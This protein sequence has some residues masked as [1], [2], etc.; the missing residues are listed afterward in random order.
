M[1]SELISKIDQILVKDRE[2]L[3]DHEKIVLNDCKELAKLCLNTDD[4]SLKKIHLIELTL[5]M[6]AFLTNGNDALFNKKIKNSLLS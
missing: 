1:L 2:S 3:L 6:T 5:K 4:E